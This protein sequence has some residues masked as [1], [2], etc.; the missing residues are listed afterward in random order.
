MKKIVHRDLKAENISLDRS[1]NIR[2]DVG[3]SNAF[4]QGSVNLFE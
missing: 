2:I 3:L 4:D 1:N